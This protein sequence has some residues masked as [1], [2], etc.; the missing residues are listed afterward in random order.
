MTARPRYAIRAAILVAIFLALH[1]F[2]L[3]N[4][5]SI[6]SGTQ[7]ESGWAGAG[8]LLYAAAW[9]ACVVA[10]PIFAIAAALRALLRVP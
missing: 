5:V 3:R 10:A 8:G 1:V 4:H 2:G 7:P 9:F 6:L